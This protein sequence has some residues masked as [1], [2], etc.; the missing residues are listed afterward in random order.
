VRDDSGPRARSAHRVRSSVLVGGG[1]AVDGSDDAEYP[2]R[3]PRAYVFG[4]LIARGRALSLPYIAAGGAGELYE[5][6][7]DRLLLQLDRPLRPKAAAARTGP[8]MRPGREAR[9]LC[10][11]EPLS[12]LHRERIAA[13]TPTASSF[14]RVRPRKPLIA[15]SGSARRLIDGSE[16]V[17]IWYRPVF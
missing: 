13:A 6:P 8:P 4:D 12:F 11:E 2:A 16:T 17:P 7:L 9:A 1:E 10:P 5:A 15:M 3:C 14:A